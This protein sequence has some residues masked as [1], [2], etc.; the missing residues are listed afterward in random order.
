MTRPP[1]SERA[2]AELAG[3]SDRLFAL[4]AARGQSGALMVRSLPPGTR[5]R[6]AKAGC[7]G[8]SR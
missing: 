8:T 1:G 7:G 5:P 6:Q 2:R 3:Q 4:A